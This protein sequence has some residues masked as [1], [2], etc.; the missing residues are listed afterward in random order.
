ML[1]FY[2]FNKLLNWLK[3][4]VLLSTLQNINFIALSA[5]C[6]H[7]TAVILGRVN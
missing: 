4:G 7:D 3:V 5:F 1:G 2:K 6:F